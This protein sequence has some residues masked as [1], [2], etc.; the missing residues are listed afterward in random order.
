MGFKLNKMPQA[1]DYRT[2]MI[3]Q[4]KVVKIA[5]VY[6]ENIANDV[7]DHRSAQ[8][9]DNLSSHFLSSLLRGAQE[10]EDESGSL[11]DKKK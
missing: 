5:K 8:I 4:K 7:E 11:Y 9:S 2:H 3:P 1:F 6:F 10:T